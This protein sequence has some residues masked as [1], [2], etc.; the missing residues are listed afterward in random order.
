MKIY[1]LIGYPLSHSFSKQWFGNLFGREGLTELRYEN[2]PLADISELPELLRTVPNLAGFN[3]TA[4]HKESVISYLDDIDHTALA[5]GAVNCVTLSNGILKGYNVDWIGFSRSLTAF[6]GSN[7]PKAII[8]GTGGAAKAAAYALSQL[9]I[10]YLLV[11]R[12]AAG[13]ERTISYAELSP[14]IIASH[15]LIVNATP[16]GTFPDIEKMP[17][18]PYEFLSEEHFLYDMV[19]NP[20]ETAFMRNGAAHGGQVTNGI[21][22][23]EIQAE[24]S[25]ELFRQYLQ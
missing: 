17:A 1:G 9:G 23:L 14:T 11:S 24:E 8:L 18:I 10:D 3:V 6:I 15:K 12:D 2:F 16:L 22:M 19:Y 5:I 25:W 4:P 21:S 7:R 13:K 20:T